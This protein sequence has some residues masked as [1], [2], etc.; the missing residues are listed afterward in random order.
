VSA[1]YARQRPLRDG[2][3]GGM[4]IFDCA[5]LAGLPCRSASPRQPCRGLGSLFS[6]ST[7]PAVVLRGLPMADQLVVR[8]GE[9]A[10]RQR[11]GPNGREG[12]RKILGAVARYLPALSGMRLL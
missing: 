6:G 3:D 8:T 11:G 12:H 2:R 7:P 5:I 9:M 4:A 1:R 10:R